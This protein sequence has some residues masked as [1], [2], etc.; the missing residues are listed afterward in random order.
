MPNEICAGIITFNPGIA[1]LDEN[2]SRLE[3]QVSQVY[4][5]DNG[6]SNIKEIRHS[7]KPFCKLIE[8]GENKGIAAALNVLMKAA[9]EGGFSWVL[10][11]DQDTRADDNLIAEYRKFLNMPNVGALCP[12]I[13]KVGEQ[14]QISEESEV[15]IVH[16]CPTSGF[17]C[18]VE[19]FLKTDGYDDWMFIDYVD[20]DICMKIEL[21][22]YKIYR[23]NTTYIVQEL[24]KMHTNKL[25][26][27][28]GKLTGVKTL[29][30]FARTYN[31]SAFRNYYYVRNSLYFISKYK[32][33][34]NA[35]NEYIRVLKWEIKKIILEPEKVKKIQSI[36]KG[37]KDYRKAVK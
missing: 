5:V 9:E 22:G 24:G 14:I 10:S 26:Y 37:Y 30:N 29:M 17:F 33:H 21:A 28:L 25:F 36:M 7:L 1:R 23:I 35:K 6:S 34:L 20:Y 32:E 15:E 4:I 8:L 18:N 2:I 16:R 19:V 12:G 27:S 3:H 31:H 11:M 13:K